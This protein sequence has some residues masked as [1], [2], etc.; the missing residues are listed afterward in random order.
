VAMF[1]AN[2]ARKY[3]RKGLTCIK[4]A[5]WFLLESSNCCL[6]AAIAL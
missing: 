2:I 3:R 5:S 1:T 6:S 4:Q